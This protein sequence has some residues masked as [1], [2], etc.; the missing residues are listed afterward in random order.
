MESEQG[1]E[2]HSQRSK[3]KN[4][5]IMAMEIGRQ[6]EFGNGSYTWKRTDHKN[7]NGNGKLAG[8]ASVMQ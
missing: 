8:N 3:W 2:N 5:K 6:V 4:R 7:G 1:M